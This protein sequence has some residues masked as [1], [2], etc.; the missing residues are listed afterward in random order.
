MTFDILYED[1]RSLENRAVLQVSFP[2]YLFYT[3][4]AGGSAE[5]AGSCRYCRRV[6]RW[7]SNNACG[8]QGAKIKDFST[9]Y[10]WKNSHFTSPKPFFYNFTFLKTTLLQYF[11]SKIRF[12]TILP[13]WNP[14]PYNFTSPK[15]HFLLLPKCSKINLGTLAGVCKMAIYI[16]FWI[17]ISSLL[18]SGISCWYCGKGWSS[19]TPAGKKSVLPFKSLEKGV[20]GHVINFYYRSP[21]SRLTHFI[22]NFTTKMRKMTEAMMSVGFS[23]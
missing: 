23:T 4:T 2:L 13:F 8:W 20:I 17:N 6:F 3:L 12:P 7:R 22:I 9:W 1:A 19:G 5:F 18:V 15:R 10:S 14:L 21:E 11:F 16:C